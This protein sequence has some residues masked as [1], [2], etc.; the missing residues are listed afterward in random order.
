[1]LFQLSGLLARAFRLGQTHLD[2]WLVEH[3]AANDLIATVGGKITP[4]TL[5]AIFFA[6]LDVERFS[7]QLALLDALEG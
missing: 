1:M 4:A 7:E 5:M 2:P 3:P 6:S